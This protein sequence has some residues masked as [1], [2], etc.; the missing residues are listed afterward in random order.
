MPAVPSRSL[1]V[2]ARRLPRSG[3]A[4]GALRRLLD[5]LLAWQERSRQRQ[6]LAQ[7]TAHELADLGLTP[8]QVAAERSK[9]FWR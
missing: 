1:S 9:P 2:P 7:L 8:E 3:Q 4:P 5:C 6:Q